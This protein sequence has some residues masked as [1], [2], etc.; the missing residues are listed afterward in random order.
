MGTAQITSTGRSSGTLSYTTTIPASVGPLPY[1]N[2]VMYIRGSAQVAVPATSGSSWQSNQPV[3]LVWNAPVNIQGFTK[4]ESCEFDGGITYQIV[5]RYSPPGSV[6]L[7]NQVFRSVESGT[8]QIT[9]PVPCSDCEQNGEKPDEDAEPQ[10]EEP[11]SPYGV[12]SE[13]DPIIVPRAPTS[14]PCLPPQPTPSD[15]PVPT[16]CGGGS[17]TGPA[18]FS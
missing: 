3:T 10:D 7:Y 8:V 5:F 12:A 17:E 1:T 9:G 2:A 6:N 18:S 15:P 14:D 4:C 16:P 13:G 11:V